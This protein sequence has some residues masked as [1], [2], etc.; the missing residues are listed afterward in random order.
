MKTLFIGLL[1]LSFTASSQYY[2]K[3]I[4]GNRESA[5][6]IIGYRNNKVRTVTLNSY[7][8]NNMPLE[9]FSIRQEFL[10]AQQALR[11]IT[12]SDYTNASYLTSYIDANGRVIKTIDSTD[13]IVNSTTY[14]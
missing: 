14:N 9:N 12:K 10:P 13:G 1:F 3:D 5:E 8:I 6:L 11:T 2:Y 4:I 7:T